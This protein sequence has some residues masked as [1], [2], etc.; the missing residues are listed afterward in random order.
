MNRF[1]FSLTPRRNSENKEAWR[2]VIAAIS[3]LV[4][5]N[6]KTDVAFLMTTPF[7]TTGPI[8]STVFNCML[9]DTMKNYFEYKIVFVCGIPEMILHGSITDWNTIIDRVNRLIDIFP[10]LEWYLNRVRNHVKKIVNSFEGNHD[11]HWWNTMIFSEQFGSG[12]DQKVSGWLGEF[13][14]YQFDRYSGQR[15]RTEGT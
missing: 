6:T 4:K 8:E 10:D 1:E 11:L 5:N 3:A 13:F 15:T 14:P 2:N 7:S 12:G 9:M